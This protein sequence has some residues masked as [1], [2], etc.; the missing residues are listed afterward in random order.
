MEDSST[1]VAET[2]IKP[3]FGPFHVSSTRVFEKF[4][5]CDK[6]SNFVRY[7]LLLCETSCKSTGIRVVGVGEKASTHVENT[8]E[9]SENYLCSQVSN[10]SH[11]NDVLV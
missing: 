3:N 7:Y 5:C 2:L 4:P 1:S 8:A 9:T 10:Y 6:H 11:L